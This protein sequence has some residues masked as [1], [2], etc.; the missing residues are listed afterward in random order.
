M[1]FCYKKF[2]ETLNLFRKLHWIK[3]DSSAK[4]KDMGKKK[5]SK[6]DKELAQGGW[7]SMYTKGNKLTVY[8]KITDLKN[9]F[10]LSA[11]ACGLSFTSI[12]DGALLKNEAHPRSAHDAP[13]ARCF[14]IF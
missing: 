9:C 3:E 2:P 14:Q 6:A 1:N 10:F 7:M 5:K 8:P 12:L 4:G 11:G 13:R